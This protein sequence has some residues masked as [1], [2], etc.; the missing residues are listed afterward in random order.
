VGLVVS[1]S[2]HPVCL[3]HRVGRQCGFIS[4]RLSDSTPKAAFA[5]CSQMTLYYC[6]FML[7]SLRVV[8]SVVGK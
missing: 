1:P 5:G 3:V 6:C 7:K 4:V 8:T 2:V